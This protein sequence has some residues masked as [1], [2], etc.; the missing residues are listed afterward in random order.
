MRSGS[1][2]EMSVDQT[3]FVYF[4][5][6]LCIAEVAM[7]SGFFPSGNVSNVSAKV[8]ALATGVIDFDYL[9]S[10]SI[11]KV[12]FRLLAGLLGFCYIAF[13]IAFS[14]DSC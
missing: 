1:E 6:S 3:A 8:G 4:T 12:R 10:L 9:S 11:L 7:S 14:A 13:L 5:K 2:T